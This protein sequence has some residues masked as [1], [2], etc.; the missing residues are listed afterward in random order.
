MELASL[1]SRRDLAYGLIAGL[2][3]LKCAHIVLRAYRD[4]RSAQEFIATIENNPEAA[5]LGNANRGPIS[6]SICDYFRS[7]TTARRNHVLPQFQ[8]DNH[9]EQFHTGCVTIANTARAAVGVTV[10]LGLIVTLVN[11][12][13]AVRSLGH[14]FEQL[15]S[16]Q[17][18]VSQSVEQQQSTI[19][20]AMGNVADAAGTAFRWSLVFISIAVMT[21]AASTVL[22]GRARTVY[23]VGWRWAQDEY[24]RDLPAQL[25]LSQGDVA[26]RL[27]EN[28]GA[29]QSLVS[30]IN[31]L[32]GGMSA[33]SSFG[34]TLEQA[35]DAI[36][37]AVDKLPGE[38]HASVNNL[39]ADLV[40]ELSKHIANI[41]EQTKKILAI[42]G[43]QQYRV[44][45]I[46]TWV[47]QVRILQEEMTSIARQ[48]SSI[49]DAVISLR[50]SVRS[51]ASAVDRLSS[52]SSDLR[53]AVDE[54]P[55]GEFKTAIEA[56]NTALGAVNA[57]QDQL[58]VTVDNFNHKSGDLELI[59]TYVRPAV[60]SL[61]SAFAA[62]TN[63][64]TRVIAEGKI[65]DTEVARHLAEL[66]DRLNMMNA[67]T[68]KGSGID[69]KLSDIQQLLRELRD[70]LSSPK[71]TS[72]WS[73]LKARSDK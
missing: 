55:E 69:Q 41:G 30:S 61:E 42:Y 56:V 3:A 60:A 58:A 32:T 19:K 14:A 66:S 39:S 16:G 73:W 35:R 44:D 65:T 25:P 15:S 63:E 70:G 22:Q 40:T 2:V 62:C 51:S 49:P 45:E 50:D 26:L 17:E 29:L 72:K 13:G 11:L 46:G 64:V 27:S 24:A 36:V 43:H 21:L 57:I 38:I 59:R 52:I 12:Q 34:T 1:M 68:N 67:G 37:T 54:L 6:D 71:S 9:L 18:A 53:T 8:V 7:F 48:L 28:I 47:Q 20:Q 5:P 23:R 33:F 10:L 31:N 4:L